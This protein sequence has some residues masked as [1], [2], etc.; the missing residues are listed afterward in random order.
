MFTRWVYYVAEDKFESS[1]VLC[2][3]QLHD[4]WR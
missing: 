1:E 3:I 4:R 2:Y